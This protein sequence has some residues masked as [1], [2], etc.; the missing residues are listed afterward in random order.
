MNRLTN[1]EPVNGYNVSFAYSATGQ[2]TNMV[3]LSG[4]TAYLYDN[5]DRLTNIKRS[6][7]NGP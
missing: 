6:G 2:R 1:C 4:W 3:D 5:R 7:R